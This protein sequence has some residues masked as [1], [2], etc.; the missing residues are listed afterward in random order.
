MYAGGEALCRY[1]HARVYI[2]HHTSDKCGHG[3]LKYLAGRSKE[4]GGEGGSTGGGAGA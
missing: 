1:R 4:K 3:D 2:C